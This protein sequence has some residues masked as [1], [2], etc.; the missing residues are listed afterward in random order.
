[1][2][3]KVYTVD[4][5][6]P[7]WS[8]RLLLFAAMSAVLV[9]SVVAAVRAATPSVPNTFA[10]GDTLSASKMNA[11]FSA[12]QSQLDTTN[13][14]LTTVQQTM[15]APDA[16]GNVGIGTTS[17]ASRLDVKGIATVQGLT[18]AVPGSDQGIV[19]TDGG[20]NYNPIVVLSRNGAVKLKLAA[21]SSEG[22]LYGT[23]VGGLFLGGTDGGEHL[24]IGSGGNVG[25]GTTDASAYKLYVAGSAG[26]NGFVRL[27]TLDYKGATVLS[28]AP[29]TVGFDAPGVGG[30]R[31]LLD[32]VTGR[33][34]I[35]NVLPQ[36]TLDV[37]GTIRGDN[38]TPSDRTLKKNIAPLPADTLGRVM[39]LDGVNFEWDQQRTSGYSTKPQIGLIAQDV[40][41]VFP[42]LVET[43]GKGIKSIHYMGVTAALLEAVKAQ[44]KQIDELK[45]HV[46]A[47]E[48]R[49]SPTASAA[50][51][52]AAGRRLARR[53]VL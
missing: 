46:R 32:G 45:S 6:L 25:I 48:N 12:L 27:G 8:K 13:G 42:S 43:D 2:K 50:T 35:W 29:G 1:M 20:S 51:K 22:H 41:K 28:V 7:R 14:A 9:L 52:A 36:Y 16:N 33:L 19:V 31:L 15:L 47:L 18:V 17:P 21:T 44:Q 34:G 3:L 24:V 38:L 53:D 5:Q 40:E 30:G 11:N 10:D 26:L 39:K 37:A 4:V 23:G 49:L